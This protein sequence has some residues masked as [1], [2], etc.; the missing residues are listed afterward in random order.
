MTWALRDRGGGAVVAKRSGEGDFA[1]A[2]GAG[3]RATVCGRCSPTTR[4]H[5]VGRRA[6]E[7]ERPSPAHAKFPP[8]GAQRAPKSIPRLNGRNA[9]GTNPTTS[10]TCDPK[11]YGTSLDPRGRIR[12]GG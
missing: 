8:R 5:S 1:G 2:E 11:S 7:C 9:P 10:P 12:G 6:T 4:A 3:G